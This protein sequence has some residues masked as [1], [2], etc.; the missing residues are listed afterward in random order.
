MPAITL[1]VRA[2]EHCPLSGIIIA[3][4][5]FAVAAEH[6]GK[7]QASLYE[8]FTHTSRLRQSATNAMGIIERGV[9]AEHL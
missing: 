5:F 1:D 7:R 4:P 9:W 2:A 3:L 6:D 8:L